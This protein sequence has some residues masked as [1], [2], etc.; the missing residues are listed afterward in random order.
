MDLPGEHPGLQQT[1]IATTGLG[2]DDSLPGGLG[3]PLFDLLHHRQTALGTRSI[4]LLSLGE[5]GGQVGLALL[6]AHVPE[7]EL[8]VTDGLVDVEEGETV[9]RDYHVHGVELLVLLLVEV[10]L[11]LDV[12][13]QGSQEVISDLL[14]GIPVVFVGY[15][16]DLLHHVPVFGVD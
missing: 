8:E 3:R 10:H 4:E 13:L 14:H 2:A 12:V 9:A 7:A 11:D 6:D 1:E 5:G 16:G 15:L